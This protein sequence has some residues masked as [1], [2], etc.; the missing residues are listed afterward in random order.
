MGSFSGHDIHEEGGTC[1]QFTKAGE[2][3]AGF[4]ETFGLAYWMDRVVAEMGRVL[5]G[6]DAEAVHDLRVALRRCRSIANV[7]MTLDSHPAWKNMKKQARRIF[8]K[9]GD[10]RDVQVMRA[11]ALSFGGQQDPVAE[12]L[13]EHLKGEEHRLRRRAARAVREFDLKHWVRCKERLAARTMQISIEGP[14]LQHLALERWQEA[15][16][17][18]HRALRNRSYAAFHRLRIGLKHFR[19][20]L[21]NFLPQRHVW[22]GEDLKLLQDT[23]G[24]LHDLHVLWRTAMR[25]GALR[26]LRVRSIWRSSIGAACQEKL[27]GYRDRALGNGSVWNTWRA[28]LPNHPELREAAEARICAWAS[29][30]D[31]DPDQTQRVTRLATRLYDE[32]EKQGLV[33]SGGSVDIR[34]VL[35]IAAIMRR[36]GSKGRGRK[37]WKAAYRMVRS[38]APPIG[39]PAT[40]LQ[41]AALVIRYHRGP[42]PGPNDTDLALLSEDQRQSV[43]LAAALLRLAD[44]FVPAHGPGI[45]DLEVSRTEAAV[46]L[47]AAGYTEGESV[48]RRAASARHPLEIVCGMPVLIRP[49]TTQR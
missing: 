45:S 2:P 19:Y 4:G 7:C 44:S 9:L 5:G 8:R 12:A 31:P 42:F 25:I 32:I 39:Y 10:L 14:A 22:W 38:F 43:I 13:I 26:D 29:F 15:R 20:T 3:V 35:H 37:S 30:R 6:F 21:E 34:S 27:R 18:H 17:L 49:L 16:Q 41:L 48:S 24:D 11:W 40:D 33:T 36:I 46:I 23:L 47:S 28:G 1:R